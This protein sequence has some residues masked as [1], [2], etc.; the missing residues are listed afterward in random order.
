MTWTHDS[1]RT[2]SYHDQC[3]V[4][5]QDVLGHTLHICYA[6]WTHDL[7]SYELEELTS[8]DDT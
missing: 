7:Y 3:G 5:F 1:D 6:A 8:S 2:L 4:L